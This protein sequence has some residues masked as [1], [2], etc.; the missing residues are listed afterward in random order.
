MQG[1]RIAKIVRIRGSKEPYWGLSNFYPC[2]FKD[3]AGLV[4]NSNEH[5]F[6]AMKFPH[7]PE[8]QQKIRD[9]PDPDNAYTYG[10][11]VQFRKDWDSVRHDVMIQGLYFKFTQNDD[12]KK[13]LLET[14]DALIIK[15]DEQDAYWGSGVN[16]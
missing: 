10:R 7:N 9:D 2:I 13:L 5:Y 1:T 16:D 3:K 12:L 14:D 4:Y 8:H 6:Q 11:A 15:H